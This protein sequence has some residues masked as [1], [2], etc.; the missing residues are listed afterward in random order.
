MRDILPKR[1]SKWHRTT[2]RLSEKSLSFLERFCTDFDSDAD[3]RYSKY[4]DFTTEKY[5]MYAR[6]LGGV[7]F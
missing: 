5:D 7:K 2:F 3:M 1:I 6:A 4:N